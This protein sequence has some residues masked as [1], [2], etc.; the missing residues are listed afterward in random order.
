MKL[1]K[2]ESDNAIKIEV[3]KSTPSI[4]KNEAKPIKVERVTSKPIIIS[5]PNNN[6]IIIVK[7]KE[8]TISKEPDEAQRID[9][10]KEEELVIIQ[11]TD[12]IEIKDNPITQEISY[13]EKIQQPIIQETHYMN[14]D[15][16]K[17]ETTHYKVFQEKAM[18]QEEFTKETTFTNNNG[19][20]QIIQNNLKD[21]KNCI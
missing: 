3:K 14:I 5:K 17:A 11:L 19:K 15:Q 16:Q 21:G 9:I 2:K 4:A 7:P 12:N 10:F 1:E 20:I 8:I 13:P 18:S 6:P